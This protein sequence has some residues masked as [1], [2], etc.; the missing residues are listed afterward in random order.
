MKNKLSLLRTLLHRFIF[1][2][3][4]V[5]AAC[6][7]YSVSQRPPAG[8]PDQLRSAKEFSGISNRRERSVALFNEASKVLLH[9]RCVNCHPADDLP[10]QGDNHVIHDPPAVR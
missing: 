10:R 7:S 1:L 5:A 8:K 4:A 6:S 9:P 3:V 2:A